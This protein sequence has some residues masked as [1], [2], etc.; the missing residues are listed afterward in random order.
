MYTL[1]VL[2]IL[3]ISF[4]GLATEAELNNCGT[5]EQEPFS[6]M[7]G[8]VDET[9]GRIRTRYKLLLNNTLFFAFRLSCVGCLGLFSD[10]VNARRVDGKP[11]SRTENTRPTR[12]VNDT[13]IDIPLISV[14]RKRDNGQEEEEPGQLSSEKYP[15]HPVIFRFATIAKRIRFFILFRNH[16]YRYF[17]PTFARRGRILLPSR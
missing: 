7:N 13:R 11:S 10:L 16:T 4:C 1:R 2:H 8:A 6:R 3:N 9:R 5:P 14:W 15:D 17:R 12:H